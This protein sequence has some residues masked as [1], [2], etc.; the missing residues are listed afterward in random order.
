MT[1]MLSH[2]R[3]RVGL[4]VSTLLVLFIPLAAALASGGDRANARSLNGVWEFAPAD[5]LKDIAETRVGN[6]DWPTLHPT[7]ADVLTETAV[8]DPRKAMPWLQW[9]KIEVPSAWE[10]VAGIDHN[11]AGWYRRKI[12]ISQKEKLPGKRLWLEFD[13]VATAAGV[14]INNEW[15]GGRVGDYA[16]WRLDVTEHFR[17]GENTLLI[18]V[19]ELPGHLTQGFL[20]IIAPHHGGIWQDVR[21]IETGERSIAPNGV[22]VE[23]DA[24]TGEVV[25]T[26]E[27][28]GDPYFNPENVEF[29]FGRHDPA[30]DNPFAP[31][32]TD[33]ITAS[34]VEGSVVAKTTVANPELWSP[35]SPALYGVAIA[36]PGGEKASDKVY[37]TFGFRSI[38]FDG[39]TVLLN[40][41]PV[42]FRSTLTW[43][44]YPRI[45]APA[46]PP[47]TVRQEFAYLLD[48]GFNAV[49]ICLMVMPDYYYDIAD[50]MGMLLWQEYPSW[51]VKYL[52]PQFPTLDRQYE[53]F[54][55][56]DRNHPS[57]VLRSMTVEAGV[58]NKNVMRELVLMARRMT[59]TPIQD[60]SSW[61][62][63]SDLEI[64]DWY[65]EDNYFNNDAWARYTLIDLPKT[66]DTLPPKPYIIGESMTAN[67]WHDSEK[68]LRV[69]EDEP[70]WAGLLGSDEPHEGDTLANWYPRYFASMLGVEKRLR[71]KFKDRLA[72]DEDVVK[73]H[74]LPQSLDFAEGMRRFQ[75]E[76]MQADPRYAGWTILLQRDVNL[77][78]CGIIDHVSGPRWTPEDLDWLGAHTKPPVTVADVADRDPSLPIAEF[79]PELLKWRDEWGYDASLDVP[80]RYVDS[81]YLDLGATFA[82]YPS[83]APIVDDSIATLDP[84]EAPLLITD[85]LTKNVVDYAKRGGVVTLIPNQYPGGMGFEDVM[86]WAGAPLVSPAWAKDSLAAARTLE[87]LQFDLVADRHRPV[88]VEANGLRDEVDPAVRW[89]RFHDLAD[90]IAYD[91]AFATRLGE[92]ALIGYSFNLDTDGGRWVFAETVRAVLDRDSTN[93]P[94]TTITDSTLAAFSVLRAAEFR[95]VEGTWRFALDPDTIGAK[96]D[97]QAT[98]FDDAAWAELEI[99]KDWESQGYDFDGV[100]W[101]RKTIEIPAD[102]KEREITLVAEGVNNAYRM[103]I[104][105]EEA[106]RFGY[107]SDEQPSYHDT[108]TTV[109]LAPYGKPGDT[110]VVAFEVIDY[111]SK[112]GIVKP[113]YLMAK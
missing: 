111:V 53:S 82:E 3:I 34:V 96:E 90:V 23:A 1:A 85:A 70:L 43:G 15:V 98:D 5:P 33:E 65:G 81:S 52:L 108:K 13:A 59:D 7:I 44:A 75:I 106:E 60:N 47:E 14:W 66:L 49:T 30:A 91:F 79:A 39:A 55:K 97:W 36:L 69:K 50:E 78:S 42:E 25:V 64:A 100:A 37:E 21:L 101:Y 17:E 45:V 105:G 48:A 9:T 10:L 28:V 113:V 93:F 76:L 32:E 63:L 51:H 57:I 99:A 87:L 4:V 86:I 27:V 95:D 24:N 35:E 41:E 104:N 67:V 46:P 102:W 80:L 29:R 11:D 68:W 38:E 61:F 62:W 71:G 18:Y 16:R 110:I 109:D 19:D 88:P 92:G 89:F 112:G 8:L 73:D 74:L 6:F 22:R 20:S 94:A 103:W 77:I 84:N 40:G 107:P 83:A 56:R 2:P 54:M 26:V 58:E 31:I 12:D 72:E